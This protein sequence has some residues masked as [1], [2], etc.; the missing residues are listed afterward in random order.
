MNIFQQIKEEEA[1]M[2]ILEEINKRRIRPNVIA[3]SVVEETDIAPTFNHSEMEW[4][5]QYHYNIPLEYLDTIKSLPR[6]TLIEDL[7]RMVYDAIARYHFFSDTDFEGEQIWFLLHAMFL[8]RDLEATESL[9]VILDFFSQE[10][11]VIEF[12]MAEIRFQSFTVLVKCGYNNLEQLKNFMLEQYRP[13]NSRIEAGVAVTQLY[14][15]STIE[16]GTAVEWFREVFQ[17]FINNTAIP[18]LI[19]T[20]VNGFLVRF[21][22][23]M[24]TKEL[25]NE[26]KTLYFNDLLGL[27]ITGDI[28]FII[29]NLYGVS[30]KPKPNSI[31]TINE[32][33]KQL[34]INVGK[35][36][37]KEE[38]EDLVDDLFNQYMWE[39]YEPFVRTEVKI[40]RN[41]LCRCGSGKKYKK[42]C[43][44]TQR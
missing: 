39:S 18:N 32:E 10:E 14:L 29:E 7:N 11:E 22:M 2:L 38:T 41:D 17:Y 15:H 13:T 20:D 3:K 23:S 26:I 6:K 21:C 42:C 9:D 40:G 19:D 43:G 24:R 44:A 27:H 8:F 33:Y 31:F 30:E 25:W 37:Q 36:I 35:I 1:K 34:L 4:L 5:Y 28:S 12:W 16:R